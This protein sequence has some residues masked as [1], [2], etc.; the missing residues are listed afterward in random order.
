LVK[1]SVDGFE[2][3]LFRALFGGISLDIVPK[4]AGI[5]RLQVEK[6]GPGLL[7]EGSLE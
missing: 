2:G 6:P 7:G 1:K 3:R 4:T 5:D